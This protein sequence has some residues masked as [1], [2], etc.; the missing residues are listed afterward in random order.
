MTRYGRPVMAGLA[1]MLGVAAAGWAQSA[2][3]PQGRWWERAE[4]AR[5]IGLTDEQM[6]KLDAVLIQHARVMVDLKAEVERAELDL[7]V[8]SDGEPFNAAQARAAFDRL[9]QARA[10]LEKERFELLVG[11]RQILSPQQ[12]KDLRELA[13]NVRDK[14]RERRLD[15]R[16][17]ERGP[18]APRPPGGNDRF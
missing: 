13:R 10:K 14:L 15:N 4:V 7:Q 1:A 6:T 16:P 2:P 9:L 12:W 3:V 11:Q 5:R 18:M 17:P 8:A